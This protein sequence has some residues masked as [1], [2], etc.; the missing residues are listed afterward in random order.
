VVKPAAPPLPPGTETFGT[1]VAFASTPMAAAKQAREQ[2][3]LLFILH[4]AGDFEE[5]CFT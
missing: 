1:S 5:S 4:V 3:K 2:Q